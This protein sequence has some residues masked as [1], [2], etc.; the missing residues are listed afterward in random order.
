VVE[1]GLGQDVPGRFGGQR[2]SWTKP[3]PKGVP[4]GR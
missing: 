2:W 3:L 4:A 1:L